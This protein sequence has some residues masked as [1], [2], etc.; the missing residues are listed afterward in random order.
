MKG[1]KMIKFFFAG[2]AVTAEQLIVLAL[3][4]ATSFAVSLM[5]VKFL[6]S[7][8]RRHSFEVF[9]WYR[10]ALSILI[11]LYFSFAK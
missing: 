11:I 4:T 8:V 6:V 2:S 9:G 1:L 3:G 5:T 7:F 10:I